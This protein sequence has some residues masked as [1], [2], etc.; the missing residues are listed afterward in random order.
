MDLGWRGKLILPIRDERVADTAVAID[1][2]HGRPRDVPG[3]KPDAVP[4]SVRLQHVARIVNQDV[5]R[6]PGFF[7][8]T[9]NFLGRLRDD[10]DDLDAS[11]EV[12]CGIVCQFTEPAAAVR[13]PGAAMEREQHRSF[14]EILRQ[15]AWLTLLGR[16][17][18]GWRDGQI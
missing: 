16:Q 6:Q 10:R 5:E 4:H 8:V 14:L 13:S 17:R 3:V 15:R 7:D 12:L 9:T 18:E 11:L 2:E 1:Q